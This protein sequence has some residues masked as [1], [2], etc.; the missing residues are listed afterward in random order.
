MVFN[1]CARG[2]FFCLGHF[3]PVNDFLLQYEFEL[4]KEVKRI[5]DGKKHTAIRIYMCLKH[6]DNNGN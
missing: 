6:M 1:H 2:W 5:I 3:Y 4:V